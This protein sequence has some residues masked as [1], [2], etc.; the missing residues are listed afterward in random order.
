LFDIAEQMLIKRRLKM[1]IKIYKN[2]QKLVGSR[3]GQG[4]KDNKVNYLIENELRYF[5][6]HVEEADKNLVKV[7]ALSK[8]VE[9][10]LKDR[11]KMIREKKF[12]DHQ[13]KLF[14][15]NKLELYNY[16]EIQDQ[17]NSANKAPTY[18]SLRRKITSVFIRE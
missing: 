17:V 15:S 1:R 3:E 5:N 14:V 4:S 18:T 9:Q 10:A 6:K 2:V 12:M 13:T 16:D 7:R 11:D 8:K